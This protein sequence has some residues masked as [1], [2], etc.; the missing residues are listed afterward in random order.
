MKVM[1]I[2]CL[3]L[4]LLGCS[5]KGRPTSQMRMQ[6]DAMEKL[7]TRH[8]LGAYSAPSKLVEA[9]T[10]SPTDIS[11][12]FQIETNENNEPVYKTVIVNGKTGRVREAPNRALERTSQ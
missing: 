6:P 11:F 3:S 2:L 4:L 10:I 1:L 9:Q 12:I 8:V 5:E 7:A